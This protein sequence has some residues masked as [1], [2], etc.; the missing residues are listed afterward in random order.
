MTKSIVIPL[1][2]T[3]R[4]VWPDGTSDTYKFRGQDTA[5]AIFEDENGRRSFDLNNKPYATLTVTP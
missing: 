1:G 5:G 2:A 3:V 4:V